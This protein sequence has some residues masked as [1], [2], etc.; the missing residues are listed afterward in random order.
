MVPTAILQ[1]SRLTQNFGP[2]RALSDVDLE[3]R[4]GEI[5]GLLGPNGAGK[6]T[7]INIATTFLKPTSGT[8]RIGGLDIREDAGKI[9]RLLG[10][11]PQ[12]ISLYDSLSAE[13]NLAFFGG[14]YGLRG[15]DL[16]SRITEVLGLLGLEERR[17][18]KIENYSGGMRRRINIGAGI[19]HK[20]RLILM[21]EPTVGVDPQSRH[22][23]FQ[24]IQDLR[25]SGATILYTTHYMEEAERLCDRV[26][27]IDHGNVIA[28]GTRAELVARVGEESV[29]EIGFRGT[30]DLPELERAFPGAAIDA[31]KIVLSSA[32]P[33]ASL[34]PFLSRFPGM[35]LELSS[36]HVLEPDLET[37]FLKLTGH[38][39]RDGGT[40]AFTDPGADPGGA[41]S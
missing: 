21:D 12:E 29:L 15:S 36:I 33:A 28:C 31:G 24:V 13:E 18:D 1:S 38:R 34:L 35:G 8:I 39:L 17:R 30:A 40:G 14:L 23:I 10:V 41:A 11:V 3:I 37:V 7:F 9:K 5:F 27:I 22:H 2:L 6:T 20:P 4:E 19:L 25:T 16:K 26:A 32:D